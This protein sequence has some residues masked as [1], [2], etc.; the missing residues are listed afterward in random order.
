MPFA[1]TLT[2]K[3]RAVILLLI[4]IN[5]NIIIIVVII[6]INAVTSPSPSLFLK[7]ISRISMREL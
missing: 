2:Q 7:N 5:N 4:N 3:D 1:S 6:I